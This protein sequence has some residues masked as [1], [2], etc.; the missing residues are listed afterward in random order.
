M[1][2]DQTLPRTDIQQNW[3]LRKP[4]VSGDNGL[5]SS[6]HLAASQIGAQILSRGGNAM[7]AAIAT[8]FAITALEPWM[9]GIGGGGFLTYY[10]ASD[11][12]VRTIHF[13]MKSP[14]R[15]DPSDFVLDESRVGGDLFSWP[16]VVDD[17]NVDGWKAI[18]VPGHM[19]GIELAHRRFATKPWEELVRPSVEISRQGLPVSWHTTLRIATAAPALRKDPV[20][21]SLFLTNGLPPFGAAGQKMPY[22]KMDAMAETLETLAT[23]GAGVFYDG[24]LARSLSKDAEGAGSYLRADDLSEYQ[25]EERDPLSFN[26]RDWKVHTVDGLSAGPSLKMALGKLPELGTE[27]PKPS[28]A[29]VVAW[30]R[31]ISDTYKDR[32]VSLGDVD[33][34]KDPACT[35]NLVAC[36][37]D[38]NIVVITQTLLSIFGAKVVAPDSGILMNNG[39]MWF[40][41]RPDRPNSIAPSKRPLSNMSPTIVTNADGDAW[42][43]AGASGGRRIFP[44]LLQIISM[45]IDFGFDLEEALHAPRLDVCG[46]DQAGVDPKFGQDTA[47]AVSKIL[48]TMSQERSVY[49]ASFAIPSAIEM[50]ATSPRNLSASAVGMCDPYSPLSGVAQG[51]A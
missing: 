5:V 27:G 51:G 50:G 12:S 10:Q 20:A 21:S 37:S 35:T 1:T 43:G 8:S 33:D 48:Q 6:H 44:C 26:Y 22:L 38:G 17:V 19:A 2:H 31:A 4:A 41:P 11:K 49:P 30:A 39:M 7:D 14:K 24:A 18:G 25:A 3:M 16:S 46:T 32:F 34:S 47:S 28:A 40:D 36:D 23:N 42:F 29:D 45:M 13:N 15:L 9:S